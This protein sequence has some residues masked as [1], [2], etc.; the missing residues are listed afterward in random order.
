MPFN[1]GNI[2][3]F[4]PSLQNSVIDCF[5]FARVG[6]RETEMIFFTVSQVFVVL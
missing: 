3:P 4:R 6:E 2:E 5:L 1:A